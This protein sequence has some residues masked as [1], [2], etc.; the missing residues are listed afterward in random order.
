MP[1]G[2]V[3]HRL[4]LAERRP[5]APSAGPRHRGELLDKDF[6]LRALWPDDAIRPHGVH[7]ALI[8]AT[9]G[10][11]L[12]AYGFAVLAFGLRITQ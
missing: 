6:L 1:A 12:S 2:H 10:A 4:G 9:A 11:L 8:I 5:E 3:P 7:I